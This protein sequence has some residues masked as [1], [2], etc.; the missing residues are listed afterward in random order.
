MKPKHENIILIKSFDFAMQA[1]QYTNLLY[2]KKNFIIA[3]QLLRSG[4]SIGANIRESQHAESA[5]DFIH[6][7]KIA[8]KESEETGYWLELCN[9]SYP[10]KCDQLISELNIIQRILT[11]NIFSAKQ[12]IKSK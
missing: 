8:A 6:K 2:D 5:A 1:I 12:N 3:N 11:K 4:T 10:D 7:M 9:R